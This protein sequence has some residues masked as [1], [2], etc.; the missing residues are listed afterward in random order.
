MF[1]KH[2]LWARNAADLTGVPGGGYIPVLQTETEAQTIP[3]TIAPSVT[4][5][6]PLVTQQTHSFQVDFFPYHEKIYLSQ[7]S[8]S[9]LLGKYLKHPH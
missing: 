9:G 5:I 6:P 3:T 2:L 4:L 1:L 8:S 7:E